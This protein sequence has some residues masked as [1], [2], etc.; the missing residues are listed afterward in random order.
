MSGIKKVVL[1]A[2]VL[3]RSGYGTHARQVCRFLLEKHEK[4]EIELFVRAV[5]WGVTP[6]LL[7]KDMQ[8]GLVGKIMQRTLEHKGE[9]DV[10]IQLQLPNE[11]DPNIAHKNIGITAAVETNICNKSWIQNCYSMDEVI[12]PS[13]THTATAHAVEYTGAKAILTDI[14]LITGNLNIEEIKKKINKIIFSSKDYR[15]L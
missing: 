13:Q 4:N 6:W 3:T 15:S 14:D 9:F 1:R 8:N 10:S 7:N 12:V 11:W 5:P 2:P